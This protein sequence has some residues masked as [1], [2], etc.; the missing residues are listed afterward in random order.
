MICGSSRLLLGCPLDCR[1]W[2]VGSQVELGYHVYSTF[3]RL[4]S[5]ETGVLE[6]RWDIAD[7]WDGDGGS[8]SYRLVVSG[9]PMLNPTRLNVHVQPPEGMRFTSLSPGMSLEG[10][11]A[12]WEGTL[13]DRLVLDLTFAAPLPVRMWRSFVDFMGQPVVR[14]GDPLGAVSTN[15]SIGWL[16]WRPSPPTLP[17]AR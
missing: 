13:T 2:P 10:D 16:T 12:V 3:V 1:R 17:V 11:E 6:F 15:G 8:G 9:Q 4:P 5:E 7:A 14:L